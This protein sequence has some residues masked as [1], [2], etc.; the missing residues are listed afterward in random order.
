[1]AEPF[2]PATARKHVRAI[3]AGPG[4]TVFTKR[5]K[6]EELKNDMT[7]LDMVN[8]IRGGT[9]APMAPTPGGCRYRAVTQNMTVEF[10]FR[11]PEHGKSIPPNELIIESARRNK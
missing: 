11:S 7:S 8:V 5:A 3:L 4:M 1:M 2:D 6:D 10:S 9:I